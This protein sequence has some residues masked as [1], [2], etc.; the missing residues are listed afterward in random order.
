[1]EYVYVSAD[2]QGGQKRKLDALELLTCML[3]TKLRSS[4]RVV[5]S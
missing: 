1:M 2:D 4:E 3:A 5:L